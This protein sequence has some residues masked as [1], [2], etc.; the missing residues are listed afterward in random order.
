MFSFC[1]FLGSINGQISKFKIADSIT[2][3]NFFKIEPYNPYL[4]K[5]DLKINPE[6]CIPGFRDPDNFRLYHDFLSDKFD[7]IRFSSDFTGEEIFP[8][9]SRYYAKNPNLLSSP[10]KNSFIM[11][12]DTNI[13][14]HLIII[15]PLR[16]TTRR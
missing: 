2:I 8:G 1:L 15:D 7:T 10:Y 12:P 16:N 6:L 9:A 11:V 5:P 13:N 4:K 3:G 14:S